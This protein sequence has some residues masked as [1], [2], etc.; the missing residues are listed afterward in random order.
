MG[1]GAGVLTKWLLPAVA[2][3]RG[4]A[5]AR[6][7]LRFGSTDEVGVDVS[8]LYS[9]P[10]RTALV[11]VCYDEAVDTVTAVSRHGHLVVGHG[12]RGLRL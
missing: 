2:A 9:L 5:P 11:G 10:C 1:T 7:G 3:P 8:D 4:I 6:G 12:I